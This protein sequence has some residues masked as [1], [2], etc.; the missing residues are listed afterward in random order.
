MEKQGQESLP[1]DATKE[2]IETLIHETDDIPISAW[3]L[4]FTG[5]AAQLARFGITVAW[6]KHSK[7]SQ[8][9]VLTTRRELSPKSVWGQTASWGLGIGRIYSNNSPEFVSVLSVSDSVAFC[10]AF[11]R[12]ARSIQDNAR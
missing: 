8:P 9:H 10:I 3:L 12:M 7:F 11:R 2:E 4:A 1:R 5:A 6:R